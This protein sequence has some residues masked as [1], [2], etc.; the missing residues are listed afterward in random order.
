[1][2]NRLSIRERS[3]Y[4]K[5]LSWLEA[6][7][8]DLRFGLRMLRKDVVVAAAAVLSL[9]LA[10]GACVAAF[11]LIDALMLRPLPVK[12]PYWLVFLTYPREE[13]GGGSVDGG[14]HQSFSYPLF[15]RLRS[16][17]RSRVDLF[18]VS[19]QGP[20]PVRF[21]DSGGADEKVVTQYVSGD[22]FGQLGLTPGRP[23]PWTVR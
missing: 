2:G 15:E 4:V 5:L 8:K 9:S 7:I 1:L 19:F 23:A 11:E 22:S 17:G 21:D 20:R 14:E 12:D 16:A 18:A 6:L 10:M 13:E 3:R